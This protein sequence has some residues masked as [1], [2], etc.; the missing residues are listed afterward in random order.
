M[1]ADLFRREALEYRIRQ[2]GPGPVLRIGTPWVRW[3]YWLVLALAAA[4]LTLSLVVP[5]ER[6]ASGP[7]LI[8]PREGT[9]VA[10][11]PAVAGS[12]LPGDRPL[13]LEVG[14]RSTSSPS[15]SR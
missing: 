9:F 8:D 12:D 1:P 11:L 7:A 2:R 10:V 5:V 4:G 3:L 15:G 6:T 13:R 14:P